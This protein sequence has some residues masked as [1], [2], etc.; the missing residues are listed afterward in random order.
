MGHRGTITVTALRKSDVER[1][2]SSY[3]LDPVGALTT[4]LR[5]T[6]DEPD[7]E[8]TALVKKAGFDC[9]TR[10]RLQAEEPAALDALLVDLNELRAPDPSH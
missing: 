4:A 5:V 3:D 1:L 8:W 6:L 10:I 9:A 7:L 2:M